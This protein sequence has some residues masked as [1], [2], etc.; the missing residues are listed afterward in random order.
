MS[1]NLMKSFQTFVV[2]S[3]AFFVYGALSQPT[4]G[5]FANLFDDIN[6]A[7][8]VQ[9]NWLCVLWKIAIMVQIVIISRFRPRCGQTGSL[10]QRRR[11]WPSRRR[12]SPSP[13]FQPLQ[14][15]ERCGR[16]SEE[17]VEQPAGEPEEAVSRSCLLWSNQMHL[18][19]QKLESQAFVLNGTSID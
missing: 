5:R 7:Y 12:R 4:N 6:S 19:C 13:G 10:R 16:G 11:R 14:Q 18:C 2:A 8:Y 15:V 3:A 9:Y 17:K 1:L